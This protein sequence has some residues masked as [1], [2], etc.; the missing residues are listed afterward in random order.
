MNHE[1]KRVTVVSSLDCA[2]ECTATRECRSFSFNSNESVQGNC[3]LNDAT[4]SIC[5]PSECKKS[6]GL[7]YYEASQLGDVNCM[8]ARCFESCSGE[9]TFLSQENI[10]GPLRILDRFG[11]LLG[12]ISH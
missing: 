12:Y 9:S 11:V 5:S 3:Q 2:M 4:Q 8:K 10:W 1:I 7:A 6:D